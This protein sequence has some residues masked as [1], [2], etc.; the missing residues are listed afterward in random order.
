ML[1]NLKFQL[2]HHVAD[3]VPK[4]GME[5]EKAWKVVNNA[6][7]SKELSFSRRLENLYFISAGI[8]NSSM[9]HPLSIEEILQVRELAG[10]LGVGFV[11]R[12]CGTIIFKVFLFDRSKRELASRIPDVYESMGFREFI[13]AQITIAN[14]TGEFLDYPECCRKW[15][16]DHLMEG[17]DQDLEAHEALRKER[18]PDPRAYYLERFVPCSPRCGNAIRMGRRIEEELGRIDPGLLKEY[19]ILRL[20]HMRDVRNGVI[21]QEKR[22]RDELRSLGPRK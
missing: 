20:D 9:F 8:R 4:G 11:A 12:K 10:R 16:L 13:V 17:T 19:E 7:F 18:R 21:L 1:D 15:F 2:D 5:A 22:R 6:S 3:L 14:L